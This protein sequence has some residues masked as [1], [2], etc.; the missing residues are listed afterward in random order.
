MKKMPERKNMSNSDF[1]TK[2]LVAIL[3]GIV[4]IIFIAFI[5]ASI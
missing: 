5:G 3:T 1:W 4:A 2:I